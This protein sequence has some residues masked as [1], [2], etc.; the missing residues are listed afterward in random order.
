[1]ADYT[2]LLQETSGSQQILGSIVVHASE[3]LTAPDHTLR[4]HGNGW[5]EH[6][7]RQHQP[8]GGKKFQTESAAALDPAI[9]MT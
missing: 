2:F 3:G 1:M 6:R 7:S 9:S 5:R 8:P 4:V